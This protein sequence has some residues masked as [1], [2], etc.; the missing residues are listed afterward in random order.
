MP[1]EYGWYGD[2]ERILHIRMINQWTIEDYYEMVKGTRA[3]S[4]HLK[5]PFVVVVDMSA[6]N[7]PP[8]KLLSASRYSAQNAVNPVTNIFVK[9]GKFMEMLLAIYR[10]MFPN[11]VINPQVVETLEEA[12]QLA[13]EALEKAA[14]D[15][16]DL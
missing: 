16:S 3:I 7:T 2:G 15:A 1:I 8:T 6:S 4:Q 14:H 9:P 10:K 13:E 5:T 12:I 11:G